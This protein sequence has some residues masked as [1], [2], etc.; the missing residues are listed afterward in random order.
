MSEEK[1]LKAVEVFGFVMPIERSSR[2][3]SLLDYVFVS[4]ASRYLL[5]AVSRELETNEWRCLCSSMSSGQCDC[6]AFLNAQSRSFIVS[7][8][9]RVTHGFILWVI[10]IVRMG[11]SSSKVVGRAVVM[12]LS[13]VS[14][15]SYARGSENRSSNLFSNL[16]CNFVWSS[17]EKWRV[18]IVMGGGLGWDKN[19]LRVM[20]SWP[21]MNGESS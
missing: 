5:L 1:C 8:I 17:L 6:D 14:I 10:M 2:H 13:I 20:K 19:R 15:V 21:A 3:L 12:R 11:V 7:K 16:D 9:S 4:L 18:F